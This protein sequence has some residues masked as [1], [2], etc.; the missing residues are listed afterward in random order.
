ME[1]GEKEKKGKREGEN[2]HNLENI[3]LHIWIREKSFDSKFL[4]LITSMVKGSPPILKRRAKKRRRRKERK[5]GNEKRK[6]E[7]R[8]KRMNRI[9][10][11]CV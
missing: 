6:E 9:L 10:V 4:I 2:I 3:F 7:E 1:G 8:E 5:K 11:I